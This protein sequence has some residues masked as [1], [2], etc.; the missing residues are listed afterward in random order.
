MEAARLLEA[1]AI[2]KDLYAE[3]KE[4]NPGIRGDIGVQEAH[5]ESVVGAVAMAVREKL[6]RDAVQAQKQLALQ[7]TQSTTQSSPSE[8]P[9]I[10]QIFKDAT[11]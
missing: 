9:A 7:P 3:Y 5:A 1:S 8:S 2:E 11:I 10:T 6:K 4:L